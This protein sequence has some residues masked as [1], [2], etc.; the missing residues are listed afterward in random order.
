MVF[1]DHKPIA[2]TFRRISASNNHIPRQARQLSFI[3]NIHEI[4]HLSGS[5]IIVV[6]CFSRPSVGS[7]DLKMYPASMSTFMIYQN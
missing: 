2:C 1:Q 4:H 7:N 6:D 3:E 5:E